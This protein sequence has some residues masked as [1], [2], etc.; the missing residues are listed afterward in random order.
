[1][2]LQSLY[3]LLSINLQP[4]SMERLHLGL[5]MN[6][7]KTLIFNYSPARLEVASKLLNANSYRVLRSV[8]ISL[9]KELNPTEDGMTE[10]LK[11]EEWSGKSLVYLSRYSTNISGFSSPEHIDLDCNEENFRRLFEKYIDVYPTATRKQKD[12]DYRASRFI[13]RNLKQ[14]TSINLRLTSE[15]L[16]G[17][18]YPF[19]IGSIGINKI[20]FACESLDFEKRHD[21]IDHKIGNLLNLSKAFEANEYEDYKLFAIAKEPSRKKTINHKIWS[22][23]RSSGFVELIAEDETGKIVEY[24]E[25]HDVRPWKESQS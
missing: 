15:K 8:I 1:M 21:S 2:K 5:L 19:T 20:P 22:N 10:V 13:K 18:L 12:F 7:G 23:L 4:S 16:K 14:R 11:A 9:K 24:A 6:D 3:S 17:L 25:A